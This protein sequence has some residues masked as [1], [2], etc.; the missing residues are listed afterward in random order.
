M[1]DSDAKQVEKMSLP[2]DLVDYILSFLHSDLITLKTCT[3]SRS[4]L[5]KLS[6]CYIYANITLHDDFDLVEGL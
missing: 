6:K 3:Q 4:T 5:S 2:T 1:S